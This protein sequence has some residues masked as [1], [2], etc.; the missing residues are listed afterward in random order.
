MHSNS[1]MKAVLVVVLCV[2]LAATGCTA[3]WI[4]IALA[5]LPVLTHMA[6]NIASL[7]AALQMRKQVSTSE[8]AA[9]QNISAEAGKDLNLLQALY[10]RYKATPDQGTFARIQSV[11]GDINQNSGTLAGSSHQCRTI[12]EGDGGC[13]LNFK[14][15]H[16]FRLADTTA[17]GSIGSRAP[18]SHKSHSS[19]C[20]RFEEAVER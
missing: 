9:I 12:G 18:C 4:K 3:E 5:D 2:S 8:A 11:I 7:V 19:S 15:G 1:I 14:H 17:T 20:K 16:E 10:D 6:L 13:K